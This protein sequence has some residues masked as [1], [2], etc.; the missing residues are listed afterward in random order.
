M[1]KLTVRLHIPQS[2]AAG[3]DAEEI[4][5]GMRALKGIIYIIFFFPGMLRAKEIVRILSRIEII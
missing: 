3:I 4:V 1:R 5:P 2:A